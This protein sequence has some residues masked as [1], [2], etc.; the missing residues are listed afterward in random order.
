M[1][2]S[3]TVIILTYNEEK[4]IKRTLESTNG[5]EEIII[6]DSHSKDNTKE[7]VNQFQNIEFHERVFDNHTN[8]WNFGLDKCKTNWVL[9]MDADYVITDALREEILNLDLDNSSYS[10]FNIPFKYCVDGIPLKG[11]ILPPRLALFDKRYSRYIQDGHTQLMKTEGK[12]GNLKNHFLH[13]DRKPLS[14]WLWAQERYADLEVSKLL[15]NNEKISFAD[16][17]RKKIFIAPVVI[18]FYCYIF[19]LGFLDGKRGLYYA[20]QRVYAELI[21]SLKLIEESFE[22]DNKTKNI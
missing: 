19:K 16:K 3:L 2:D 5:F 1:K 22:K 21:I 14:R 18:F 13:D 8:Q 20:F 4:N 17:L 12:I 11:T 6:V 9:S 15:E 10:G 7:I